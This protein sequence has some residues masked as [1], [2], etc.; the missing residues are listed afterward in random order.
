MPGVPPMATSTGLGPFTTASGAFPA[1]SDNRHYSIKALAM[2][3]QI[4]PTAV[5]EVKR[6]DSALPDF[7]LLD[8]AMPL[9]TGTPLVWPFPGGDDESAYPL[10]TETAGLPSFPTGGFSASPSGAD[11]ESSL[12]FPTGQ[13]G[14]PFPSGVIPIPSSGGENDLPFPLPTEAPDAPFPFP[15]P[16]GDTGMPGL[17]TTMQTMTRG[18]QPTG[19]PSYPGQDGGAGGNQQ[20]IRVLQALINWLEGLLKGG[21]KGSVG[22]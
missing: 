1:A 13:P 20:G 2:N 3:Y 19:A 4:A 16:N 11:D 17:P 5:P 22:H 7:S 15:V 10:P 12:P 18:P 21:S 8:S 6:Q 14:I 9:P